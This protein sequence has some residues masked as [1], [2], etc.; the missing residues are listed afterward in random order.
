LRFGHC[1]LEFIC[2]LVLAICYFSPSRRFEST[3]RRP[4]YPGYT[5]VVQ[6]LALTTA[7]Q[8]P[9]FPSVVSEKA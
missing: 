3:S 7:L 1:N 9:L 5:I 8:G 2:H 6:V 4:F